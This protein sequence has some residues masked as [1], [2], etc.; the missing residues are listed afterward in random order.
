MTHEERAKWIKR[1][2]VLAL[3]VGV[4][5]GALIYQ[6]SESSAKAVELPPV[7]TEYDLEV[8]HYH[9]PEIPESIQIAKSLN[10]VALKYTNIVLVTRVDVVEKPEAAEA[11][12]ATDPPHVAMKVGGEQVF[13]FQGLWSQP[14]IERKI[15]ELLRGLERMTKDWRPKVSGMQRVGGSSKNSPTNPSQP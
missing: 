12:G 8:V 2:F 11:Q 7:S 14:E 10:N 1:I 5:A 13:E 15:E 3:A 6:K 4:I 9:H